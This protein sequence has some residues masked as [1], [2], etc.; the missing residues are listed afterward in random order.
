MTRK[1][2]I[3]LLLLIS[4]YLL[5]QFGTDIYNAY[6]K[7]KILMMLPPPPMT[8]IGLEAGPIKVSLDEATTWASVCKALVTLLGTYLGIKLINK[9]VKN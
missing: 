3:T 6:H 8:G 4:A 7:P 1:I 2:L 5:Y 9:Y